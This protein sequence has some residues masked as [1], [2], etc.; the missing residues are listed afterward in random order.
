MEHEDNAMADIET[1]AEKTPDFDHSP[2][3]DPYNSS[4]F[5]AGS[6][7]TDVTEDFKI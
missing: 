4:P 6:S 5:V 3:S 7:T 2:C 1:L